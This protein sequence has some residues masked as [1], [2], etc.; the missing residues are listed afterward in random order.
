MI[1]IFLD[2][3]GVGATTASGCCAISNLISIT[4][5]YIIKKKCA[6]GCLEQRGKSVVN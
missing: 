4:H 2:F 1:S 3:F 5:G 6:M